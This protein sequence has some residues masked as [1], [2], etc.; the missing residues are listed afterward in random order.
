MPRRIATVVV[1]NDR[2][3]R[4]VTAYFHRAENAS[5]AI[6]CGGP[7]RTNLVDDRGTGHRYELRH[8]EFTRL[9]QQPSGSRLD[10]CSG[11]GRPGSVAQQ[12][13]SQVSGSWGEPPETTRARYSAQ[14]EVGA[15]SRLWQED[16][17]RSRNGSGGYMAM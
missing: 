4:R 16:S 6:K 9:A 17:C 11:T 1:L 8:C 13:R 5:Q 12:L 10:R 15:V 7:G 2:G 3:D 14:R